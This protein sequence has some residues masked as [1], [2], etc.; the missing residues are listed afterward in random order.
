VHIDGGLQTA[1]ADLP[2]N[3]NSVRWPAWAGVGAS[4]PSPSRYA[5]RWPFA[6]RTILPA[7]QPGL[8]PDP[9]PGRSWQPQPSVPDRAIP[10]SR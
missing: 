6:G 10:V 4:R 9:Q 3:T 8:L 5:G 1:L 7:L 2:Q